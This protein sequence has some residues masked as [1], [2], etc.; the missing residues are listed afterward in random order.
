MS[1]MKPQ[2]IPPSTPAAISCLLS[3]PR[4]TSLPLR[5][6]VNI[7]TRTLVFCFLLATLL[8]ACSF[9]LG[10]D[11]MNV[12]NN[13][14]EV[15]VGSQSQRVAPGLSFRGHFPRREDH[16]SIVVAHGLCH[17][18]YPLPDLNREPW[19]SLIGD[20]IKFRWFGDGRMVAY[21][22]TPDVRIRDNP[23]RASTDEARTTK[24][25][26]VACH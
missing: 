15:T 11:I 1:R 18:R 25:M 12:G 8:S 13:D 3:P 10:L 6:G 23:Q 20:S 4:D 16:A 22:P 19:R 26:K 17:Y 5:E 2:T 7:L 24:P 14:V 21:P 9:Q